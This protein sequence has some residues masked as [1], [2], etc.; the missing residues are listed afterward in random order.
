MVNDITEIKRE[1]DDLVIR[2]ASFKEIVSYITGRYHGKETVPME[3]LEYA[4]NLPIEITIINFR[5]RAT[6]GQS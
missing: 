5:P 6:G 1:L 4:L 2:G 3:V